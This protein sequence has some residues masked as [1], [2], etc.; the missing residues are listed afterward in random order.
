MRPICGIYPPWK[1]IRAI[2]LFAK[3]IFAM[4]L[5]WE[6]L[7]K[8]QKIDAIVHF[9]AETHVDRSIEGPRAFYETNVGGTLALLEV[10][11]KLPHIHLSP[12]F[13]RMRSTAPL[14]RRRP[15]LPK[16]LP[17]APIHLTPPQRPPQTISSAHTIIPTAFPR[18]FLIA[19]TITALVR[20]WRSLFR[21]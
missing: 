21:A 4:N 19:R 11:R 7:C 13:R 8:E 1:A 18:R 16:I 12:I 3:G 2:F 6:R 15:P 5:W 10:V 9:A 17:T 14:G 20:M